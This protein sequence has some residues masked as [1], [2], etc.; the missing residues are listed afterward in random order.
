MIP[1]YIY[2]VMPRERQIFSR[3]PEYLMTSNCRRF[4]RE[5]RN[6]Y[7]GAIVHVTLFYLE[8]LKQRSSFRP[9]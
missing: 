6:T 4:I 3:Q 2:S 9:A 5:S 8:G 1:T 7:H